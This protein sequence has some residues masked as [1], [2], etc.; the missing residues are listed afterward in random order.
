M[1]L[2]RYCTAVL[3][4]LITATAVSAQPPTPAAPEP[5]DATFEVFV[6]GAETGRIVVHLTRTAA[7]WTIS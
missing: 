2:P 5:G 1:Q 3:L 7:G 4:A 6:R